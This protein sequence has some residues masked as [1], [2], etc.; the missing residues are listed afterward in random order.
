[1][2]L[3][4]PTEEPLT[5]DEAKLRAG[6]SWAPG[7]PRDALMQSF[8]K[9]ARQKVEQ[10]TGLALLQQTRLVTI[11]VA[12]GATV[13]IPA[14]TMPTISI[15]ALAPAPTFE[16]GP[17]LWTFPDDTV[18]SWEVVAGWPTAVALQAEAPLLVQAV[19]LLCAH[20]ATLGRDLA[21]S[22]ESFLVPLGYDE[23]IQPYRVLWL[24]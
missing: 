6:L 20:M 11:N 24:V 8:I 19:G 23:A 14:Q 9:A 3:V 13:P 10:D 12:A 17:G 21:S 4:G 7:D 16:V 18:G 22:E 5:L 1:M 2:L 15:T